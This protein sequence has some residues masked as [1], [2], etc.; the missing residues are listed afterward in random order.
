MI[1][2]IARTSKRIKWT[3]FL[4]FSEVELYVCPF[5][6]IINETPL[7]PIRCYRYKKIGYAKIVTFKTVITATLLAFGKHVIRLGQHR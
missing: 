7:Y 4:F 5:T 1:I 3:L 6:C 2:L